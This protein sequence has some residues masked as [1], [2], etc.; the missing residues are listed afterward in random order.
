MFMVII[1]E[2]IYICSI[3]MMNITIWLLVSTNPSE[4]NEFLSV[5]TV[6]FPIDGQIKHIQ[7]HQ[8][9]IVTIDEWIN[10]QTSEPCDPLCQPMAVTGRS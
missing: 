10:Q 9:A 6:K 8:P 2:Y 4:K 3:L 1:C 7:N 5:G